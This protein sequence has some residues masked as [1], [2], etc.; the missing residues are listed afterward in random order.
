MVSVTAF[1]KYVDKLH[2]HATS[3]TNYFFNL[4]A[5]PNAVMRG[6]FEH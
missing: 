6:Q 5:E 2:E 4:A 3:A 1:V